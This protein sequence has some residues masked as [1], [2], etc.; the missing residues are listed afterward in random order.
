M[1]DGALHTPDYPEGTRFPELAELLGRRAAEDASL[2]VR[3]RSDPNAF[4]EACGR[5]EGQVWVGKQSGAH[6]MWQDHFTRSGSRLGS[7][8]SILLAAV[9]HAKST[10]VHRWRTT[11]ELGKNPN[12]RVL[13]MS[14]TSQ[15]PEKMLS[16]IKADIEHNAFVQAVFPHLRPGRKSGQ[17]SWSGTTIHVDREDNLT[18]PTIECAGLTTK[19]LGSRKDL[20]IIDDLLNVENTLTPYMRKQVWDRVQAEALSRRPPHLPSR[21]WFLGHPWTEDDGLAQACQQP[22]ARVLR[23]GARVQRTNAGRIIT[24]ADPEWNEVIPWLPLIPELWTK[25][26]LQQRMDELGWASRFM[27]DCLFMRRGQMGFSAEALALALVNGRGLSFVHSWSP[28][29]TGCDTYTGVDISTGEAED[30]T[31]IFTAAKLPNGRRRI[32]E[33]QAGKWGGPEILARLRDV[34][35]R[36][37][38]IIAIESNGAQK[39]IRQF[40]RDEDVHITPVL[41]HHTGNNKHALRWGI[42]HMEMELAA[43]GQW[44]FPRPQDPLAPICPEIRA[45]VHGAMNYSGDE[46]H[47]SDYLMAWWICWLA[48]AKDEGVSLK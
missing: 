26:A 27:I 10:Q 9:G 12:L 41:D 29:A 22:G 36:F 39:L 1:A 2:V 42:K 24:S 47:T 30:E 48:M 46:K 23:C 15:L 44:M 16:G 19:I 21:A 43:P 33:I 4:V 20:I 14:A 17:Q 6:R 18:D 34:Y 11:W 5:I 28:V 31:V 35:A 40:I 13:L 32:L 37:K 38:S 8:T 25:Q 3:A 45:L 7:T